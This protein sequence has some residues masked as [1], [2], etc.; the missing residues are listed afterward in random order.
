MFQV[1]Q[2][3]EKEKAFKIATEVSDLIIYCRSVTFNAE[4][5]RRQGFVFAEM[6]SFAE[7]KA[8]RMICKEENKFFIKYHQV[9]PYF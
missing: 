8:E 5:L 3:K 9:R 7:N 1:N 2:T 6:S 4:R